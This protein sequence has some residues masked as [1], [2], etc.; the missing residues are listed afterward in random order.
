LEIEQAAQI[1]AEWCK[2]KCLIRR[3]HFFGS[4]VKGT[5]RCDSDLDIAIELMPNLDESEGLCTWMGQSDKWRDELST[6]LPYKVQL[7]WNGAGQTQRIAGAL[8][9]ASLLVYKNEI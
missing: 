7:E 6:L 2:E 5:Q 4:R 3:A 9:E 1:V 8:A